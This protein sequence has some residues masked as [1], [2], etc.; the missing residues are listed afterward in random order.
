[1]ESSDLPFSRF[2]T[3]SLEVVGTPLPLSN[4]SETTDYTIDELEALRRNSFEDLHCNFDRFNDGDYPSD[5]SSS[6]IESEHSEDFSWNTHSSDDGGFQRVP[7]HMPRLM[8]DPQDGSDSVSID[9]DFDTDIASSICS[10]TLPDLSRHQSPTEPFDI[11]CQKFLDVGCDKDDDVDV[12][13]DISYLSIVEK[14]IGGDETKRG[15]QDGFCSPEG[16]SGLSIPDTEATLNAEYPV[17]AQIEWL[18][19]GHCPH[20]ASLLS[21]SIDTPNTSESDSQ[22]FSELTC[23]NS[24]Q[25]GCHYGDI[26]MSYKMTEMTSLHLAAAMGHVELVRLLLQHNFDIDATTKETENTPVHLAAMNNKPSVVDLLLSSGC[27]YSK[28]NANGDTP[29]HIAVGQSHYIVNLMRIHE[30]FNMVVVSVS[31]SHAVVVV[32][33]PAGSYKRL[34]YKWYKLPPCLARRH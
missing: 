31:A 34:S 5:E 14:G 19:R 17:I 32:S 21:Q 26:I 10:G 22:T 3:V 8:H 27:N 25:S 15:E 18:R 9:E 1:M 24:K 13:K 11:Q 33:H 12:I 7:A 2:S 23:V 6:T 28:T 4:I 20:I 16:D 29:M 30:S